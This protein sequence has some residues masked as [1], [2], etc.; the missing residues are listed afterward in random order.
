M[1][2]VAAA[3][4]TVAVVEEK[5]ASRVPDDRDAFSPWGPAE[6][7]AAE[8]GSGFGDSF[9]DSFG[10]RLCIASRLCHLTHTHLPLDVI[11]RC[12][13]DRTRERERDGM[14]E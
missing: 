13:L 4:V 11:V 14:K 2:E 10:V 1:S 6:P 7:A 8:K 5:R 12:G 9:G 3:A